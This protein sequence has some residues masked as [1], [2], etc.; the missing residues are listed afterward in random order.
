MKDKDLDNLINGGRS[1]YE[2]AL[3]VFIC[4]VGA[5]IATLLAI[6]LSAIK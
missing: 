1:V 3:S 5:G 6:L 4:S 2:S